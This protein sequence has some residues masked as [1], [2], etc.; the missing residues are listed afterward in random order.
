MLPVDSLLAQTTWLTPFWLTSLGIACGLVLIALAL[1]KIWLFAKLPF[2]NTIAENPPIRWGFAIVVAVLY[3]GIFLWFYSIRYGDGAYIDD[4]SLL[5]LAFVFPL[6]LF[7]GWASSGLFSKRRFDETFRLIREGFL[8]WLGI[9]ASVMTV[10]ALLGFLFA[11][12]IGVG[13]FKLADDPS[14]LLQS[15]TRLPAAG[16]YETTFTVPPSGEANS[17]D[18]FPV[19]FNGEEIFAVEVRSDQRIEMAPQPIVTA[20]SLAQMYSTDASEEWTRFVRRPDGNGRIP[21]EQI[22]KVYIN[23]LGGSDAT[24]EVRWEVEPIYNEVWIVPW[25]AFCTFAVYLMY[26][27]FASSFPKVGAIALST[28]KTEMS[29]PLYI[30][31]LLVGLV[32]LLGSI[33]IPYNTFGEDIK[34]YKDSGLTLIR[35]LAIFVAIWA[36]GKSVAEEIEGRTAL[37]VLSKPVGRRQFIFGK[38]VGICA[39]ILI[40]FIILGLWF[41]MWTGYKPVYDA[42]ESSRGDITWEECFLEATRMTP[43]LF[44]TFLEVTIFVAISLA[45]STRFGILVNFLLCFAIYVLGHLTPLIVNSSEAVQA[46]EPV[47]LFGQ[48]IAIIFPVLDHFDVQAAINSNSDVPMTYLGWSVIYTMLYGG[49]AM[50]LALVFFEDRDLA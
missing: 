9:I 3:S 34:M 30:I 4:N 46:F 19:D 29:Q 44:L 35:V 41:E 11:M 17:G 22:S 45:I 21:N 15:I 13:S 39:A 31:V 36:A 14:G 38:Y 16:T 32:F 33:W 25:T 42:R 20:L 27:A 50:L 47:V 10:V 2:F 18:E 48:V 7:F 28:F 8:L 24:V 26:L 43:A 37:T 40:M 5:A 6:S 12:D 1:G 23:N 49:M